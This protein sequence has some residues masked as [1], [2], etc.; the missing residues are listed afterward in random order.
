[1]I[2]MI[3]YVKQWY[4]FL[5]AGKIMGIKCKHC[6]GYEFPP[7]PI[8]NNCSS[9]DV[10]WVEMSGTGTMLSFTFMTMVDPPLASFGPQLCGHVRLKEGPEFISWLV[11]IDYSKQ[12]EL[13]DRLPMEVHLEIQKRDRYS[14]PVFRVKM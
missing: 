13:Y 11:G 4:G 14:Y 9:T 8:C 3:P 5:E 12:D 6:G 1:M 10:E 2:K 7:V